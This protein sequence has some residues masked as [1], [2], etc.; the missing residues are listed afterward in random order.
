MHSHSAV[1]MFRGPQS[2]SRAPNIVTGAPKPHT[3]P[4]TPVS[5]HC[6]YLIL[7]LISINQTINNLDP[8]AEVSENDIFRRLLK[9]CF[10]SE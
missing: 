7:T 4:G 10:F 6:S 8:H 9:T 5:N 2:R 1:I 3:V